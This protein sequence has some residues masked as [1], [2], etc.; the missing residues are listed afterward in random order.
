MAAFPK[1]K[2]WYKKN[3]KRRFSLVLNPGPAGWDWCWW[4]VD[5]NYA[6]FDKTIQSF[7]NKWKT[8]LRIYHGF[9][10]NFSVAANSDI[11]FIPSEA[12]PQMLAVL[13]HI[14]GQGDLFC[15]I[16][17]TLAVNVASQ[18]FVKMENGYLWGADKNTAEIRRLSKT[19]PFVHPVKLAIAEQAMLWV[20]FMEQQLNQT[21]VEFKA[22]KQSRIF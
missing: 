3:M 21:I 18:D 5:R 2:I 16:A 19:A 14:I 8:V 22:K 1:N 20:S 4:G 10:D 17:T 13:N 12:V 15:E 9:P 11:I 6:K 7:P